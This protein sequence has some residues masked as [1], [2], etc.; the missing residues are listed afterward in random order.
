[1]GRHEEGSMFL[2]IFSGGHGPHGDPLSDGTPEMTR[3]KI[4]VYA[5]PSQMFKWAHHSLAKK[6]VPSL[7]NNFSSNYVKNNLKMTTN[8]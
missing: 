8:S 3:Y 4:P 7:M 2:G 6:V 1:M 5:H